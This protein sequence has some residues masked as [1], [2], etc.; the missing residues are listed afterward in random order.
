MKPKYFFFLWL[1]VF[2]FLSG[3]CALV[4]QIVW[5]RLAYA[6]FGITT[7]VLSVVLSVFMTGLA[8]GSWAGGNLG[9]FL[10]RRQAH[11]SLFAYG[12]SEIL[13]GCG[14]FAA[15]LCFQWGNRA[16]LTL[17]ATDSASY[18][19]FSAAAI[20][21]SL[22]PWC[23]C[24]GLTL[25]LAMAS[26]RQNPEFSQ[27]SFSFLYLANTM[28]ALA[29]VA[30]AS[31]ALIELRGFNGTLAITAGLNFSIGLAALVLALERV[32]FHPPGF[33]SGIP[34]PLP[35]RP[36]R[37]GQLLL[38]LFATGFVSMALEVIWTRAYTGILRTQVYSFASLLFTY[39]LGTVIGAAFYR[40]DLRRGM[41][42]SF[43]N[44]LD[45]IPAALLLPVVF[46]DTRIH[47]SIA[48]VLVSLMPLSIVL[49][50][51]TPK[52]TDQ[53]SGGDPQKAGRAYAVNILGCI[54]GP[55]AASYLILPFLGSKTAMILTALVFIGLVMFFPSMDSVAQ[56]RFPS[57][58]VLL[59][60]VLTVVGWTWTVSYEEKLSLY[61][62]RTKTFRDY[63]ATVVAGAKEGLELLFVNGI[64][65][66]TLTPLPKIMAHLPL[67]F[68]G[69]PPQSVLDICFGMGTT[70]RSLMSWGTDTTAVDLNPGVFR[71]FS[72]FYPDGESLVRDPRAHWVV[73]D[74][75]RFLERTQQKF[76]VIT[77]D[78][79]PP[80]E[81]AG[82]SLLYSV[83]FYQLAK[84]RLQSGGILQQWFPSTEP[85]TLAAVTRS[86]TLSFAYVRAYLSIEGSGYHFIA[87]DSPLTVPSDQAILSRM[88]SGARKDLLELFPPK[89][90]AKDVFHFQWKRE[91]DPQFLLAG[92]PEIT[93]RDD[94][95]YNEYYLLRDLFPS[96]FR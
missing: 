77:I 92:N 45:S 83:E 34:A 71:A 46:N 87:S 65:M 49:G 1:S 81:A 43:R 95:P 90:S 73:D 23:F 82:S 7:P 54:L 75:R 51:L 41:D 14:A 96:W 78:P 42:L 3:F 66:T 4:Y 88:P 72:F 50:Y 36:V 80:V 76:D 94:K 52:L 19:F 33:F 61:F 5:M 48:G 21:V 69:H 30:A 35:N 70:F 79:P 13:I 24:M 28:G 55:L 25:P 40:R 64:S 16:L 2:F 91:A 9:S 11:N 59:A 93:L 39:L 12:F 53:L 31:I 15:P 32:T 57:P 38:I 85:R 6:S 18:L 63:A 44:L 89:L 8:L 26:L 60:L 58:A 37:G 22:L 84:S 20:L 17:G 74:G 67:V 10:V 27:N 47:D 86:L 56:R 68:L 62:P 29:G